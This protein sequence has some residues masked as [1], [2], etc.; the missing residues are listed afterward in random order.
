MVGEERILTCESGLFG[1][2]DDSDFAVHVF[3]RIGR[4]TDAVKV[5]RVLRNGKAY[6]EARLPEGYA[7]AI[8]RK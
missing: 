2:G 4:E 3:D 8:V 5:P 1:W 6:A 7:A